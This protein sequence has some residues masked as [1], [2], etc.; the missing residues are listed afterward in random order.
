MSILILVCALAL[1]HGECTRETAQ[2]VFYAPPVDG[3]MVNCL[4]EGMLY[5][6]SSRLVTPGT[7]A[8]IACRAPGGK[9][10]TKVD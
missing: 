10:A 3:G 1:S 5:A 9:F 8:K 2:H 7:Y 6:A 4:R